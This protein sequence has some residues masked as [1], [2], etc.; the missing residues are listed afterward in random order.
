MLPIM[1]SREQAEVL[2][3]V[4]SVIFY[5]ASGPFGRFYTAPDGH[6][7]GLKKNRLANHLP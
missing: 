1:L 6:F 7:V 3:P 5:P 4:Q 2:K